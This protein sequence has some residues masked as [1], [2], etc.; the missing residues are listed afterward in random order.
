MDRFLKQ[1][2]LDG[3]ELLA[4]ARIW[5]PSI[6]LRDKRGRDRGIIIAPKDP[7]IR[8]AQPP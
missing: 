5:N 8:G 3:S 6:A 4:V 1:I 7:L 2:R